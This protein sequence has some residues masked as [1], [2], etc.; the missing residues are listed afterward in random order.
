MLRGQSSHYLED[1]WQTTL[2]DPLLLA[3]VQ[4]TSKCWPPQGDTSDTASGHIFPEE[5]PDGV[6]GKQQVPNVSQ[7][8]S[9]AGAD[10]ALIVTLVF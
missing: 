5:S 8:T 2:N 6:C 1:G 10:P 7:L 9:K 3:S 4:T